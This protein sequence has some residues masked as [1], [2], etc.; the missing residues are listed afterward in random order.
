MKYCDGTLTDARIIGTDPSADLAVLRSSDAGA[1]RQLSPRSRRWRQRGRRLRL[2]V[3]PTKPI[4]A[5]LIG[6]D[7]VSQPVRPHRPAPGRR[8]PRLRTP[9]G[10]LVRAVSQGGA[11]EKP[12]LDQLISSVRRTGCS[13]GTAQPRRRRRAPTRTSEGLRVRQLVVP[14]AERRAASTRCGLLSCRNQQWQAGF[15]AS[16]TSPAQHVSS[17]MASSAATT[18]ASRPRKNA[19]PL[20]MGAIRGDG[21]NQTWNAEQGQRS[22]AQG[23]EAD[24]D[25]IPRSH[26]GPRRPLDTHQTFANPLRA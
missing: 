17:Q 22:G 4:V 26:H 5:Q 23:G 8:R 18:L 12:H 21:D 15:R 20:P 6:H 3:D 1:S 7:H 2:P 14:P 19:P 10:L 13:N 25:F 9:T 24:G 11:A 16:R